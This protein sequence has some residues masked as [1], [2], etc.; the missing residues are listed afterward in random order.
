MSQG[1]RPRHRVALPLAAALVLAAGPAA[2]QQ[3]A[4]G[5]F[6]PH[7][8][9][10]AYPDRHPRV[11]FDEAH[12]NFHTSAG[13][14]RPFAQLI[15]NDGYA[16]TPNHGS[17]GKDAL[18]GYDVLIIANALGAFDP[19]HPDTSD[20]A[21]SPEEC[22]AVL[23]WVKAGGS[24]LLIADHAP[25]GAAAEILARR[26]GVG[27][28]GGFTLDSAH[29]E[30]GAGGP[31]ILVYS[32]A[33]GLLGDHPITRGRDSTERIR[34]VI[35]FTGQS[36]KGPEGSAAFLRLSDQAVDVPSRGLRAAA[37][38]SAAGR[39]QGIALEV[40]KG[41]VAVMGEAAMFS[42]QVVRFPAASGREPR[43]F[44][45]GM[46]VAGTDNQ[47]LALNV[48]HWLSGLLE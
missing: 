3:M 23:E 26:F 31:S 2:S 35:A 40:G 39:A 18:A 11:L 17:F 13:R 8:A 28:S 15:G 5:T 16:V 24:L 12:Q 1:S 6:V 45:M 47:Q 30:P 19:A 46:N 27:M 4:D 25:F 48:M 37:G 21:F 33:N 41:R 9:R 22:D 43:E 10:P 44:K 29:A 42:A 36:L 38:V 14:Y 7:V 20:P 34:R 32:R